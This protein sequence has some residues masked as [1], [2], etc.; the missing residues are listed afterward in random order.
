MQTKSKRISENRILAICPGTREIGIAVFED[1]D[2]LY[3]GTKDLGRFRQGNTPHSLAREA[4]RRVEDVIHKYGPQSLVLKQ[5]RPLQCLNSRL[6]QMT[7]QIK[8]TGE[9]RKLLL[10]EREAITARACLCPYERPTR[11][12][13]TIRLAHL[14]PELSR[15]VSNVTLW[16]RHYYAPMFDAIA[17]GYLFEQEA[18]RKRDRSAVLASDKFTPS[19]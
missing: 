19:N 1:M 14:Y 16:Q 2:L 10:H 11:R 9:Q 12:R 4:A 3:Y 13:T 18:A 7:G 8:A 15:Y 17:V 5:L 6:V